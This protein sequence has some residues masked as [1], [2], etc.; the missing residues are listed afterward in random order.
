MGTGYSSGMNEVLEPNVL[1][2]SLSQWNLSSPLQAV[3]KAKAVYM[4]T[5][6]RILKGM[7][8][9]GSAVNQEALAAELGVSLRRSAKRCGDWKWRG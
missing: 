8:A 7:L 1:V 5:R 4:E 6:S 2:E 3:T 9:P